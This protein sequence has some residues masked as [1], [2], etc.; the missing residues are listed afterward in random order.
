MC[1]KRPEESNI[2]YWFRMCVEH[3]NDFILCVALFAIYMQ[4]TDMKGFIREQT[5]ALQQVSTQLTE[6]NLRIN[7]LEHK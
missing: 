6:M 5:H 3:R 1:V 4:Y 7:N 2:S